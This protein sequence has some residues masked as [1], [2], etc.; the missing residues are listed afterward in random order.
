MI[1]LRSWRRNLK[2]GWQRWMGK[3]RENSNWIHLT[4]QII[5]WRLSCRIIQ[6]IFFS[7]DK[8][9]HQHGNFDK[10]SSSLGQ[11]PPSYRVLE[12][13]TQLLGPENRNIAKV[14]LAIKMF[15]RGRSPRLIRISKVI[16][17]T[18]ITTWESNSKGH[19]CKILTLSLPN[20]GKPWG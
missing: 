15:T 4:I 11:F 16:E 6:Q 14:R 1:S 3:V 13:S 10:S 2:L 17:F 18:E 8:S 20:D 9:E 5:S 12:Q 19:I 7:S